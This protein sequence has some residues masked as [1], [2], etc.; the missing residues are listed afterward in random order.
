MQRAVADGVPKQV[1]DLLEPVE[2]EKE[3]GEPLSRIQRRFDLV[4]ELLVEA[5]AIGKPREGVMVGKE[6][7]ASFRFLARAEI[8]NSNGAMRLSPHIDDALDEFD[9]YVRAVAIAQDALDKRVLALEE[10]EAQVVVGKVSLELS[11][12]ARC[13]RRA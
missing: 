2:V 7:D 10:L 4:I 1:V 11:C 12:R 6:V 13:R 5:G 9:R 3:Y 8:P